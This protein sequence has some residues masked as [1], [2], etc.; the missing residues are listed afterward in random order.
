MGFKDPISDHQK[1]KR[2]DGWFLVLFLSGHSYHHGPLPRSHVAFQMK[3]LLPSAEDGFAVS[4]GDGER[5][6]KQR[7]LEMGVAVAVMPG[8]F[9][10]VVAAGRD[11]LVE[12]FGKIALESRFEL[13]CADRGRAA[14][15][16]DVDE[17][18][19]NP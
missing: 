13:D 2:E 17:A 5:W 11:E 10:S 9:V 1:A 15:G 12:E 8:L 16:E 18:G 14:D 4:E 3:D 19:A 7:G 6:A